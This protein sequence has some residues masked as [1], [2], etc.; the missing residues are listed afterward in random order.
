MERERLQYKKEMES[1]EE[2]L[3]IREKELIMGM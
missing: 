1:L 2:R 3:K